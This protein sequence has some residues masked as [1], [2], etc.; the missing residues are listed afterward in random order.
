MDGLWNQILQYLAVAGGQE[1]EVPLFDKISQDISNVGRRDDARQSVQASQKDYP[2]YPGFPA[3]PH[4]FE[5]RSDKPY[6]PYPTMMRRN[7]KNGLPPDFMN[8]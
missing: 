6:D 2:F 1:E 8:P 7:V 3:S 5:E 4:W